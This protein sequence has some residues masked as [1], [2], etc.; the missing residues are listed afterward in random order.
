MQVV[1]KELAKTGLKMVLLIDNYPPWEP[2][3][4]TTDDKLPLTSA[5][6]APKSATD[7]TLTAKGYC[8]AGCNSSS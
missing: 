6:Y 5:I 4:N 3:G 8:S 1:L 2:T 7:P